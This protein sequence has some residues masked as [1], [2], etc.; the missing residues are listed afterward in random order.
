MNK[1]F[2]LLIIMI[3]SIIV[4]LFCAS[5]MDGVIRVRS[6]TPSFF[7]IYFLDTIPLYIFYIIIM[8][9]VNGRSIFDYSKH[10]IKSQF[11]PFQK[12]GRVDVDIPIHPGKLIAENIILICLLIGVYALL[13]GSGILHHFMG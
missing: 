13:R 3:C 2:T 5:I 10:E 9:F 4:M 11:D 12:G 7:E 8:I 6:Y 1:V